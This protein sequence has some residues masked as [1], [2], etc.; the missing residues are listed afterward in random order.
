M[1]KV[2]KAAEQAISKAAK[3]FT[4]VTVNRGKTTF[5]KAP[6]ELLRLGIRW[7]FDGEVTIDGVVYNKFQVQP[8]AGKVPSTIVSWREDNGGTHAVMGNMFVRKG[9]DE[10]DVM[11]GW[12]KFKNEFKEK[13]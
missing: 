13:K 3:K 12:E 4:G 6:S 2:F 8:N 7:D 10:E 5:P 9:G 11:S 1:N